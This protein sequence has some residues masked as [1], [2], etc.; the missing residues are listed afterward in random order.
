MCSTM[1]LVD[2]WLMITTLA[3]LPVFVL[4]AGSVGSVEA[5]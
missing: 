2:R 5:G 1:L 4:Q 3:Y